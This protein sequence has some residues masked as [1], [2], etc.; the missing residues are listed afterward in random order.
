VIQNN[1]IR[2]KKKVNEGKKAQEKKEKKS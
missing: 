1:A 2:K